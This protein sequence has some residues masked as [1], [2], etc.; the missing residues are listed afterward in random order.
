MNKVLISAFSVL[1]ITVSGNLSFCQT[2][3]GNWMLGANISNLAYTKDK[4]KQG[5]V[6]TDK[7]SRVEYSLT[8]SVGYFIL[9][10][11][12]V[13]LKL[14]VTS[15]KETSDDKRLKY[16]FTAATFGPMARYYFLF[17]EKFGVFIHGDIGFG[18]Q[19]EKT[20][21]RIGNGPDYNVE[22]I[23][24]KLLEGN[25]GPGFTFFL[26]EHVGLET[27]IYYTG[28]RRTNDTPNGKDIFKQNGVTWNIGLQVYFGGK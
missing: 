18:G 19:K 1:I 21:R 7:T 5:S 17:G 23:K 28:L 6:T 2:G 20:E 16:H 22:E 13:G 14:R 12:A 8:P 27:S 26:N 10:N 25:I 24:F 9:E 15:K 4:F 11:F 3:Q